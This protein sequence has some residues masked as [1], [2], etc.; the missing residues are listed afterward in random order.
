[1]HQLRSRKHCPPRG[2]LNPRYTQ[3]CL[4]APA[5]RNPKTSRLKKLKVRKAML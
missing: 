1:M 3:L 2:N 5:K 4:T